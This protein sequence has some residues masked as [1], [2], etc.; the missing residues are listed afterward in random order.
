MPVQSLL[1][2]VL[3]LLQ[4]IIIEIRQYRTIETDRIFYQE[5]HLHACFLY[6]MFKIHLILYQL[7][8]RKN[9][10]GVAKPA[11]DIIEDTQVFILHTLGNTMRERRK[12]NTMDIGKLTLDVA[13]YVE[14][15]IISIARHANHQINDGRTQHGSSLFGSRNLSKGWRIT[16]TQLHIF[17][18]YLLLDTSIIFKH[19][20]IVRIGYNQY[21][22]D[23]AHHQIHKRYV[24]QVEFIPLLRYIIFHK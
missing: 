4:Y 5:N 12:N 20:R 10:I 6:V 13:R 19:E 8:D 15:I 3:A 1:R 7:D 11:E 9:K 21:I 2:K 23:T 18:I 22:V 17:I 24:F 14:G 16:E